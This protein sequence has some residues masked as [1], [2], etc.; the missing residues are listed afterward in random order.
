MVVE[1]GDEDCSLKEVLCFLAS[2]DPT[3]L[4]FLSNCEAFFLNDLSKHL[5]S[6][7]VL[8]G[9]ELYEV[10]VLLIRDP[11]PSHLRK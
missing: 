1:P 6:E 4:Q 9:Q 5:I 7:T 2:S 8:L 10:S 11:S 3:Q